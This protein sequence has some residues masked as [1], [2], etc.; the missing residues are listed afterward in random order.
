MASVVVDDT[1]LTAIAGAIRAQ[2]EGGS[3]MTLDE[4]ASA[5]TG[6]LSKTPMVSTIEAV[7]E[8]SQVSFVVELDGSGVDSNGGAVTLPSPVPLIDVINSMML[9]GFS[10]LTISE[11]DMGA[12]R[13]FTQYSSSTEK[14]T[15]TL[16][17]K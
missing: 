14:L 13:F 2:L 17:V 9:V 5:I 4:M 7:S 15:V 10:G 3:T 11:G 8:V 12:V 1:K 6:G 16:R